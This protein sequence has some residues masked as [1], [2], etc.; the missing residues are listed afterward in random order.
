[1]KNQ[2]KS[3]KDLIEQ[4]PLRPIKNDQDL[5]GAL[6]VSEEISSYK[7][8]TIDQQDYYDVLNNLIDDYEQTHFSFLTNSIMTNEWVEGLQT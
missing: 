8:R 2:P 3:Y 1:M 7:T 6:K 4:F 5:D